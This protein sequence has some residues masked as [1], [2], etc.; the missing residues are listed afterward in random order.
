VI[1]DDPDVVAT[2]TEDGFPVRL[3]DWLPH[4]STLRTAQETEGRT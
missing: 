3:A 1:D 4:S 2:L